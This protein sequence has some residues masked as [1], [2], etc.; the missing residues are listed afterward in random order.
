MI[1]AE[2]ERNLLGGEI[3]YTRQQVAELSGIPLER[4]QRL[5]I[6]MGFAVDK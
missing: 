2:I 6:A 4:A 5:W 3:K 1:Q